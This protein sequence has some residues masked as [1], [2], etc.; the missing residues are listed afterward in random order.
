[1]KKIASFCVDHNKLLPGI[2]VSREDGDI[3]TYDIR[4]CTPNQPPFLESPVMHTIEHLF[5]TF[6][7]NSCYADQVIYFGPMGCRTG[8]YFLVREMER[9]TA[10]SLILSILREIAAYHGEIPGNTP[11]ECGNYREH[12]LT[13]AVQTAAAYYD[14]VKEW[15]PENLSYQA[16]KSLGCAQNFFRISGK[17]KGK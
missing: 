9:E 13:G 10:L 11:K 5:A 15:K 2:Y 14:R 12:N 1:M 16:P 17:N 4:M 7:R 3:T 8:F 6:A